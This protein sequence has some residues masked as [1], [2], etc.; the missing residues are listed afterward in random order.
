MPEFIRPFSFLLLS[1]SVT[2]YSRYGTS[3]GTGWGGRRGCVA[4]KW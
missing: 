2:V 4:V 1:K 3:T